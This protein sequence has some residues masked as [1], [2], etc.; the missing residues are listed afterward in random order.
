[1]YIYESCCGSLYTS[2]EMLDYDDTYCETCG[3][4]DRYIGY[5]KNKKEA[6]KLLKED[7]SKDYII[8][9]INEN[10]VEM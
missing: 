4:S 6:Y 7:Y 10:W 2:D 3:D 1:M 5:A 8:K 9:F